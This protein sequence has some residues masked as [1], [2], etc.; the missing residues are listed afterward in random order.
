MF[1]NKIKESNADTGFKKAVALETCISITFL[2]QKVYKNSE[3]SVEVR[4]KLEIYNSFIRNEI[5]LQESNV[6]RFG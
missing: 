6:T 1:F 3:C 5:L 2:K 4:V